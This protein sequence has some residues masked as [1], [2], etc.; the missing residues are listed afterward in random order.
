M[1]IFFEYKHEALNYLINIKKQEIK[2]IR[3]IIDKI[4]R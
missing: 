1:A 3:F 2:T 4:S